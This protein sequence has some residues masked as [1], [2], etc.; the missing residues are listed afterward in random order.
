MRAIDEGFAQVESPALDKVIAERLQNLLKDTVLDPHLEAAEARGV[1]R[2]ARRHVGPRRASAVDPKNPV[3]HIARVAPRSAAT[4]F[5][6]FGLWQKRLDDGPLLISQVHL[7][8][9][10]QTRSRVDREPIHFNLRALAL[11]DL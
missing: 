2:I 5:A 1:R 7:D 11:R 10:S 9:R 6:N 8:L 4:V 3:E